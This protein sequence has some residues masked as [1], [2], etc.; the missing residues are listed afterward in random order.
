MDIIG[1]PFI[2][3]VRVPVVP[4]FTEDEDNLKKM[5][6]FA[7][8][9]ENLKLIE[10]LPYHGMAEAKYR[11]LGRDS[12]L[13]DIKPPPAPTMKAARLVFERAR[14]KAVIPGED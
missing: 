13:A 9:L 1:H 11:H 2:R 14:L 10:L 6:Q 12:P 3:A 4:G 5:A 7:Q 8:T